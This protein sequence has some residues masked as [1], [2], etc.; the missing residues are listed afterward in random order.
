MKLQFKTK[1]LLQLRDNIKEQS[2]T[3]AILKSEMGSLQ[4]EVIKEM[5][6][7]KLKSFK[8]DIASFSRATRKTLQIVNEDKLM[9]E[10]K[11]A[12]LNDY[13]KEQVDK[14]LFK[15]LSTELIKDN[16]LFEGTEIKSTE[17]LSIKKNK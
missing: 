13:V 6:E 16:K 2:E 14:D 9:E 15:G 10:L 4:G 3:L 1:Q 5:E 7:M 11:K 17:F 8:D 12:G